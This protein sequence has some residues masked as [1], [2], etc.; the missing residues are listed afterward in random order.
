VRNG[1]EIT[2]N[3][4]RNLLSQAIGNLLDNAVK[5]TPAGGTITLTATRSA[6]G[7]EVSVADTGPG[8]PSED[9]KRVLQ[10]YVRLD[11]ARDT[12]GNGLGLSL[13]EAIARQHGA[14]FTLEDNKPGLLASIRFLA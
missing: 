6:E 10:R 8:I 7:A 4:N 9:R 12:E 1:D 13:V 11:K 3:G 5:F 14:T 2:V